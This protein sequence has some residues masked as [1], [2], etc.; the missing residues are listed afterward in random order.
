MTSSSRTL[1][2]VEDDASMRQSMER[3]LGTAGFAV[4][5]YESAEVALTAGIPHEIACII[6]DLR[7][8]GISGLELLALLRKRGCSTPLIVITAFDAPGLV[9]EAIDA[10][11]VA[12]LVKPFLGSDLLEAIRTAITG[13]DSN[14]SGAAH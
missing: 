10:G 5:A 1:L 14:S 9:K 11:A 3:L 12:Y 6:S 7:L 8:P 13:L 4:R 2:I